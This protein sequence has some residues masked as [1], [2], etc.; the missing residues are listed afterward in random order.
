VRV[1][2]GEATREQLDELLD[3]LAADPR[4]RFAGHALVDVQ[5]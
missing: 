2:G 5:P 4:V 3:A 1:A